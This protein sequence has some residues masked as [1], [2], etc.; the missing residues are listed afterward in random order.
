[1]GPR[2]W[3]QEAE[4]R[5]KVDL[6]SKPKGQQHTGRGRGAEQQGQSARA[7]AASHLAEKEPTLRG[8]YGKGQQQGCRQRHPQTDHSKVRSIRKIDPDAGSRNEM[9]YGRK[10]SV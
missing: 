9:E 1:M 4:K 2:V 10:P 6:A 3:L 8:Q 5:S 7:L